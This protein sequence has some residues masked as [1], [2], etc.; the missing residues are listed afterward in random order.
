MQNQMGL[1]ARLPE[2]PTALM[3]EG[4]D[5][6][7]CHLP[8]SLALCMW[9]EKHH[10]LVRWKIILRIFTAI[11]LGNCYDHGMCRGIK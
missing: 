5:Q 2:K 10:D 4:G 6:V 9:I 8:R 7:A 3:K 11:S 1:F